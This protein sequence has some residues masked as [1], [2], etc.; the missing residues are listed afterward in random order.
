MRLSNLRTVEFL[1][2]NVYALFGFYH[3]IS[4]LGFMSFDGMALISLGWGC[5]VL[6]YTF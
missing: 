1:I 3:A 2:L 5:Q 6:F 4:T